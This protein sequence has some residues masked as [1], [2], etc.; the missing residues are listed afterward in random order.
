ML[1]LRYNY[2]ATVFDWQNVVVFTVRNEAL[3]NRGMISG[4]KGCFGYPI[5]L[6]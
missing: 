5:C 1:Q 3:L 4:V 6:V 2:T